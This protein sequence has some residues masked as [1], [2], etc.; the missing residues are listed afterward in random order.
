[1]NSLT[2][3]YYYLLKIEFYSDF[4]IDILK[5]KLNLAFLKKEYLFH[6]KIIVTCLENRLCIIKESFFDDNINFQK[7]FNEVFN[8]LV[9]D[10]KIIKEFTE[11]YNGQ[12]IFTMFFKYKDDILGDK[13]IVSLSK[14]QMEVLAENNIKFQLSYKTYY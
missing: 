8:S 14:E 9:D 6:T 1:M 5:E 10:F 3:V 12:A 2:N 7:S 13:L 11:K 4:D